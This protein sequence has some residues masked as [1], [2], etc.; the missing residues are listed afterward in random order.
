MMTCVVLV[1]IRG[2]LSDPLIVR[3]EDRERS[4]ILS[5]PSHPLAGRPSAGQL[6]AAQM[7]TEGEDLRKF[8]VPSAEPMASV[9]AG[10]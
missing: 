6:S 1:A 3:L 4:P 5:P 9:L 7:L 2:P 10:V 8:A